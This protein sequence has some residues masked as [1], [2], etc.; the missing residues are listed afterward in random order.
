MKK[1][2][3][4]ISVGLFFCIVIMF[5]ASTVMHGG[6][7]LLSSFGRN[8]PDKAESTAAD[9]FPLA[10]NWRSLYGSIVIAAGQS[11]IGDVYAADGRLIR[12]FDEYDESSLNRSIDCLNVFSSSHEDIPMY[13]MI[14]PTASGVYSADLPA[15]ASAVDQQKLIDDI[16]Y[17]LDN[18]I[19]TLDAF[20]PLFM[21]R[22]DYIYYKTDSRWTTFGA[23]V[24]YGSIAAKMGLDPLALA[25]YDVEYA[26]RSFFGDLYEQTFYRGVDADTINVFR[27]KNG[28]FV[29]SVSA[30]R[31]IQKFSSKSVYYN[32]ALNSDDKYSYFLGGSSFKKCTVRTVNKDAPRLLILKDSYANCFVPFLTPHYSEITLV[33]TDSFGSGESLSSIADADSFDQVLFLFSAEDFCSR[34]SMPLINK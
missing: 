8:A 21:S 28:S 14:V 12:V 34:K 4:C 17:R 1:I 20:S 30:Q 33:D 6:K 18:R 29:K 32:P 9:N 10:E 11:K 2:L 31:G 22:D 5:A 16:Y 3:D 7:S 13:A 15:F 19:V 26:D 23:Y 25:N 27:N 24:V